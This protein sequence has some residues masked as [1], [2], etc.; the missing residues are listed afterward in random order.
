MVIRPMRPGE[1]AFA[2]ECAAREGW[3]GETL[4]VFEGYRAYD[5]EGCLVAEPPS[6]RMV[7]APSAR[8]GNSPMCWAIG[9][10]AKG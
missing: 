2:A 9:S 7:L 6:L 1:L 8:L 5:P 3:A 10:P 4:E